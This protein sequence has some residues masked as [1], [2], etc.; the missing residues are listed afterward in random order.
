MASDFSMPRVAILQY[1]DRTDAQLG[2]LRVLVA[3]NEEYAARQGYTHIFLRAPEKDLPPYW[4]KV[5]LI[6]KYLREGFDIVAWL[7]SDA[8]V[9]DR[10]LSIPALFEGEAAFVFAGEP[11]IWA[12]LS[13]FNAGVFFCKGSFA[14]T[15]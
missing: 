2:P 9:H 14:Q 11:P 4:L 13:P 1:D 5:H 12:R 6:E 7:D 8:V 10:R 15:L 3:R